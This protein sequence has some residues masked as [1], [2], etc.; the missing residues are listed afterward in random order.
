MWGQGSPRGSAFVFF[1]IWSWRA[2]V[3]AP[4]ERPLLCF[5]FPTLLNIFLSISVI[6]PL[7]N[8]WQSFIYPSKKQQQ[9]HMKISHRSVIHFKP[10]AAKTLGH[11]YPAAFLISPKANVFF[12]FLFFVLMCEE[13]L[14][15]TSESSR[16]GRPHNGQVGGRERTPRS[17]KNPRH[18][19]QRACLSLLDSSCW[20]PYNTHTQTQSVFACFPCVPISGG[21]LRAG[22]GE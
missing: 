19:S 11:S 9:R 22:P 10:A 14:N 13:P 1:S 4:L 21:S 7:S 5:F 16:F 6:L 12:C 18:T 15:N 20:T 17:H 3:S 2:G 8:R